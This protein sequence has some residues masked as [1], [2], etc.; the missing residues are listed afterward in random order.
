[1]LAHDQCPELRGE[2]ACFLSHITNQRGQTVGQGGQALN[3]KV[4]KIDYSNY[5]QPIVY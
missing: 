1:M 4:L 5:R 3:S 2:L